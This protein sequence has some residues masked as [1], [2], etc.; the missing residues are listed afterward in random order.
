MNGYQLVTAAFAF[1]TVAVSIW[2]IVAVTRSKELG[3]KPLWMI[4]SLLGFIGF[5]LNWTHPDDLILLLV[6]RSRL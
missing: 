3:R 6:L 2:A 4:G 1:G 5:G